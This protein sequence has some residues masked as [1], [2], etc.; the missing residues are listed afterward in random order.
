MMEQQ[1]KKRTEM[2]NAAMGILRNAT[3]M[4]F[5]VNNST[6]DPGLASLV[7]VGK[8]KCRACGQGFVSKKYYERHRK[9]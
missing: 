2:D 6:V 1:N 7:P 3:G 5:G 4:P 9:T 8:F